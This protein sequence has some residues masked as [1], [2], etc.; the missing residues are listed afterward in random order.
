MS[1][2][3]KLWLSALAAGLVALIVA[4]GDKVTAFIGSVTAAMGALGWSELSMIIGIACTVLTF[5]ITNTVNFI[6][7]KKEFELKRQAHEGG[8]S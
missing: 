2:R 7:R 8:D 3:K 1:E 4:K 6:F 5:I